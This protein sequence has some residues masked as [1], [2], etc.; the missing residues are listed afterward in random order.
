MSRKELN[1]VLRTAIVAGLVAS[2]CGEARG[3]NRTESTVEKPSLTTPVAPTEAAELEP[4]TSPTATFLPWTATVTVPEPTNTPEPVSAP[5]RFAE[6]REVKGLIQVD[7][8]TQIG[9]D[10]SPVSYTAENL[11]RF[12]SFEGNLSLVTWADKYQNEIYAIHD[13]EAAW[14]ELPVEAL[15]QFIQEQGGSEAEQIAKLI[16]ARVVFNQ[17]GK[18]SVWYIAALQKV[19]HADVA[20]FLT[21]MWSVVDRLTEFSQRDGVVSQFEVARAG[22]GK[23]GRAHV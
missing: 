11:T 8:I 4:T 2:A 3:S 13:G 16:E 5:E 23:I 20:V 1:L 18:E 12:E 15:R 7:E 6:G 14:R 10:F 19:E 21:D 9:L 22:G 17:D